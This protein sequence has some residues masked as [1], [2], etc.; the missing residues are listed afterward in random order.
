MVLA[1][2]GVAS[3]LQQVSVGS[4]KVDRGTAYQNEKNHRG[5]RKQR[6]AMLMGKPMR[7]SDHRACGKGGPVSRRQMKQ[8][9]VM[10][11]RI[12]QQ[13]VTVCFTSVAGTHK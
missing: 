11:L 4:P 7:P 13:R 9:I 1:T 2:T 12:S 10:L 5:S 6:E 3:G 8:L